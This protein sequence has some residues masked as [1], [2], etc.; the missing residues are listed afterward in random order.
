MKISVVCP[1]LNE[2]DFIGYSIMA[3]MPYIHEFIYAL[4]EKSN[5]GT[6]ELLFH[7]KQKYAHEKLVILE[8]PNFK[9]NDM[10][11]Y[12]G[13]FNS[14]IEK[15]TGDVAMFLHPDMIITDGP[16]SEHL[17]NR[18]SVAWWTT[19]TSYAGDFETVITKGRC[20][21]WKNIHAKKFGLHYY[22]GYGSVNEDF[23]HSD[24]TGRT[25]KHYGTDFSK[26][27]FQVADSGIKIN[28]YCE[29]KDYKRRLEKMKICIKTQ[30]PNYSDSLVHDF[31]VCHPRVTL[32]ETTSKFGKFEFK[33]IKQKA[34]DVMEKYKKEFSSFKREPVL[35]H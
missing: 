28:H 22:G 30:N 15:M 8:T 3:G 10:E 4:D 35:V 29:L 13:S 24:I 5:D 7:M 2:V 11:P 33:K 1:V 16:R 34:P 12:N 14:C 25:Y 6:R 23:Y 17:Y 18:N 21:K 20:D 9:P 27:P 19:L 32:E 31:A 26:Y